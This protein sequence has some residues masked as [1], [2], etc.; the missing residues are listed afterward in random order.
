M[1]LPS[2]QGTTVFVVTVLN[3]FKHSFLPSTLNDW[4]NLD[5]N[6]GNSKSISLFKFRLLSFIFSVQNSIY[7]N[8]DPK[9]LKKTISI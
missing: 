5:V 8:L 7:N 4:F 2:E 6:I 9:G 1:N 3:C